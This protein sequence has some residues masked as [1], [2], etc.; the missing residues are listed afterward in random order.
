[1]KVIK[2]KKN[3]KGRKKKDVFKPYSDAIPINHVKK[4][5]RPN[6]A[7]KLEDNLFDKLIYQTDLF[8]LNTVEKIKSNSEKIWAVILLAIVTYLISWFVKNI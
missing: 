7:I 6:L 2:N 1:M 8:Y 3:L 5:L 4:E